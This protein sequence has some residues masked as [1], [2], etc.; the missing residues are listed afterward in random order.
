[1]DVLIADRTVGLA[2]GEADGPGCFRDGGGLRGEG[3]EVNL[4]GGFVLIKREQGE[5]A[6]AGAGGEGGKVGGGEYGACLLYTSPSPRD[7]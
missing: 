4:F 1:V 5:D 3:G 2:G 6:V 7:V